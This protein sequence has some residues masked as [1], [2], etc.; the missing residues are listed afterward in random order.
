MY[1]RVWLPLCVVCIVLY[2]TETEAS[3]ATVA[4]V[5]ADVDQARYRQYIEEKLYTRL[6][7]D[8]GPDGTEHTLARINIY[9]HFASLGYRTTLHSFQRRDGGIGQNVVAIKPGTVRPEQIYV[10]G[11][12]YDTVGTP[13]ADDNASGVAG[14][15]EAARVLA[16]Y[17]TEATVTFV[18][19]DVEE[20]GQEG[21]QA[22][23]AVHRNDGIVAMISMDMISYRQPPENRVYIASSNPNP[24]QNDLVAAFDLYGN[25]VVP[26]VY[27]PPDRNLS[28]HRPFQEFTNACLVVEVSTNPNRDTPTDA[29]DQPGFALDYAYATNI[30][31]AVV[32]YLATHAVV[33]G[34]L[35]GDVNQDGRVN[36]EDLRLLA[37]AW[38]SR[39]GDANYD[40]R[41]DLN[42]DGTV[43]SY[44]LLILIQDWP[45]R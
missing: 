30:T 1:M 35:R 34:S 6:G 22:Y 39:R 38:S 23:A 20:T 41:R 29:I 37:Q 31:R 26:E 43:S 44:D 15:M 33:E 10:L 4:Q 24:L 42:H 27:D 14:I 21:S 11:A 5:V 9:Q 25:G 32:G 17:A 16:P 18:A 12:H 13:G 40:A 36:I 28:D 8:R 2:N 19:F 7:D 3:A 45:S